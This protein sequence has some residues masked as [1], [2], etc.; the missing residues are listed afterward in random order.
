MVQVA[1]G[2]LCVEVVPWVFHLFKP[3][4]YIMHMNLVTHGYQDHSLWYKWL[5]LPGILQAL[6]FSPWNIFIEGFMQFI[7]TFI[8]LCW[9]LLK[10][11]QGIIYPISVQNRIPLY[12]AWASHFS[13][14]R[15]TT[16]P[17]W[18]K[19]F[20]SWVSEVFPVHHRA[21]GFSERWLERNVESLVAVRW[22]TVFKDI[23]N[24][25]FSNTI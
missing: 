12:K 14:A 4:A 6:E 11:F 13:A 2:W 3:L 7:L 16:C 25:Q 5:A 24:V 20:Y 8:D 17:A 10:D 18:K 9:F 21:M 19:L 23:S 1:D 22:N 15:R